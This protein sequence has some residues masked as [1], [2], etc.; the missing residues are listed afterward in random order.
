[1]GVL[2]VFFLVFV[3]LLLLLL[4]QN[5]SKSETSFSLDDTNYNP[6]L[7]M[8]PKEVGRIAN[9]IDFKSNGN[10]YIPIVTENNFVRKLYLLKNKATQTE[11]NLL[12]R[13]EV[14]T[15]EKSVR[16]NRKFNNNRSALNYNSHTNAVDMYFGQHNYS[17]SQLLLPYISID[18][19]SSRQGTTSFVHFP[20]ATDIDNNLVSRLLS[21]KPL[22]LSYEDSFEA[23]LSS[24]PTASSLYEV[25]LRKLLQSYEV[26]NVPGG[27]YV[28]KKR[29]YDQRQR[30]EAYAKATN[31]VV[32]SISDIDVF[33]AQD[34][35]PLQ[36]TATFYGEDVKRI[37][38]RLNSFPENK[39]FF[40]YYKLAV[41]HA[42]LNLF[43][44]SNASGMHFKYNDETDLLEPLYVQES[45]GMAD[46]YLQVPKY[47]SGTFSNEYAAWLSKISDTD[48]LS[49]Y[50]DGVIKEMATLMAHVHQIEPFLFLDKNVLEHNIRV[51]KSSVDPLVLLE[52]QL[53]KVSDTGIWLDIKNISD[54]PIL[55]NHITYKGN[56]V[57]AV[58][59]KSIILKGNASKEVFFDFVPFHQNL[60]VNKKLKQTGFQFSKHIFDFKLDFSSGGE[61]LSKKSVIQPFAYSDEEY[62]LNDLFRKGIDLSGHDFLIVDEASK[63]ITFQREAIVLSV[64]LVIPKGY[65][66]EAKNLEIDIQ[67]GGKIISYSP[68]AFEGSST[69][70]IRIYSSDN[71]GQGILVLSNSGRSKMKYVSFNGLSNPEH[72]P[73]SITGAVT[74]YESAVDF[75]NVKISNNH[76]EDGINVV[77]TEFTMDE[78]LF[79]NIQSDAFDGDFVE[80]KISNSQFRNLGNDAIDVS[81]SNIIIENVAITKAGDK[82][83]SAGENSQMWGNAIR[84]DSSEIAVAGKDLSN[85]ELTDLDIRFSKLGFTAFQKKPEFGPSTIKADNVTMDHIEIEHLIEINSSL[86]INGKKAPSAK[87]VKNKMYGVEFGI[88][89]EE[90]RK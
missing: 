28:Y 60:F 76:C 58:P 1:M 7:Q 36:T 17:V 40:D 32:V 75:T 2:R 68:I 44:V 51:I 18:S 74:F 41:Y 34:S 55:L 66:L 73:W 3:L 22:G 57:I 21:R 15:K 52:T 85:V 42:S 67:K 37:S 23:D 30:V 11:K 50:W 62:A 33:F 31:S 10:V 88:S 12:F 19:V 46:S 69:R 4:G 26:P 77:R 70:P 5:H 86:T 24:E 8:L 9:T 38:E 81:G 14:F 20:M 82:G 79:E 49:D 80:G 63:K 47:G 71:L 65:V 84:I 25:F 16:N 87:N 27:L 54:H 56:K 35:L 64:P 43:G 45:L 89:S 78:M 6:H 13:Y 61:T 39:E 72:G 53:K 29:L 48:F 59:E 83:L 90:T